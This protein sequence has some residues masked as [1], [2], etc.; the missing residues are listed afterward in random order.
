MPGAGRARP[1]PSASACCRARRAWPSRSCSTRPSSVPASSV[2]LLHGLYWLVANLAERRR[3]CSPSTMPSGRTSRRCASWPTWAAAPSRCRW[4]SSWRPATT[5]TPGSSPRWSSC[6]P[7]RRR[8]P[9]ACGAQRRGDRR[10]PGRAAQRPGGRRLRARLPR[11]DRRQPVPARRAR[12]G[13]RARGR[14]LRRRRR[15]ARARGHATDGGA[16]GG[17]DAR[18][19]RSAAT[20]LA[21]AAGVLGDAVA[22]D[23]AAALADVPRGRRGAGRLGPR[24]RRA[25]SRTRAALRFRHPMLS[26]A[27]RASLPARERAAAHA[28]AARCCA[29][30]A[31]GRSGRAAAPARRAGR[32]C[33]RRRRAGRAATRAAERGAP[34]TAAALLRRRWPS[35]RRRSSARSCCSSSAVTSLPSAAPTTRR[36]TSRRRIAAPPTPARAARP[37]RCWCRRT[38]ATA[39]TRARIVARAEEELPA[40][41]AEDRELACGCGRCSCWTASTATSRCCRATRSARPQSWASS[42]SGARVS[43]P[44]RPRSPTCPAGRAAGRGAAGRRGD[45]LAAVHRRGRRAPLGR[46][47]RRRPRAHRPWP[48]AARRSGSIID[49]AAALTLRATVLRRAGRLREAEA[50]ARV[51][52]EAVLDPA[53]AF[54]RGS[55]RS[56]ERS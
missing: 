44:A 42:S 53:V 15:A 31:P 25:R 7:S 40:L 22:L 48:A 43:A 46:P 9:C 35:R 34:A 45:G 14:G 11:S 6:A 50:D 56:S 4:R 27:V 51:A 19:A 52:L 39:H 32:R 33:P 54:A 3:C 21:Q 18:A 13:A 17:G 37:S 24:A 49:F 30:A 28:R 36:T 20:A 12:A 16:R 2:G 47:P 38:R 8:T 5:R 41:E 29:A 55:G 26:G 1:A 10:A 23:L